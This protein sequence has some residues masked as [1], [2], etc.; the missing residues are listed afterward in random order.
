MVPLHW[1]QYWLFHT[2]LTLNLESHDK[3][4]GTQQAADV[5]PG[6]A[7]AEWK[8]VDL[9]YVNLRMGSSISSKVKEV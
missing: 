9:G 3:I 2:P 5:V 1:H 6:L 4:G 8:L 7:E